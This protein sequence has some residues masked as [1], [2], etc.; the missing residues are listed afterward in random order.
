MNLVF[1][2]FKNSGKS[3]FGQLLAKEL[4]L[5]FI[6]IDDVILDFAHAASCKELY[7][8]V[9]EKT[10]REIEKKALISLQKTNKTIIATGGGAIYHEEIEKLGKIVYLDAPLAIL[11]QRG[12]PEWLE[13]LF[14]ERKPHYMRLADHTINMHEKTEAQILSELKEIYGK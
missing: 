12:L 14:Y 13:G 5:A 2:G 1:I 10:F 11:K 6:D 8:K 7:H 4:T 3:H 9:G